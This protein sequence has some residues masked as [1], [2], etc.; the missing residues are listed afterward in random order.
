MYSQSSQVTNFAPGA[1]YQ[2]QMERRR[3]EED[4]AAQQLIRAIFLVVFII[5]SFR[6]YH[7]RFYPIAPF[8]T[9]FL[10]R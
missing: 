10:P 9:F 3:Q 2:E 1:F 5:V 6:D 4:L 8:S 7:A